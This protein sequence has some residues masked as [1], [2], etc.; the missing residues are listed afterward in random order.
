MAEGNIHPTMPLLP[1]LEGEAGLAQGTGLVDAP[2]NLLGTLADGMDAP[3]DG[4]NADVLGAPRRGARALDRDD[5]AWRGLVALALLG[6]ALI[7]LA[8]CRP[9]RE[10]MERKMFL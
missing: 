4:V 2:E 10:S 9:A 5:G 7:F 3:E 1:D 8:I 6:G